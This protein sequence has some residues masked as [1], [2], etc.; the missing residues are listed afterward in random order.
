VLEFGPEAI[1]S[2]WRVGVSEILADHRGNARHSSRMIERRVARVLGGRTA[3]EGSP[4]DVEL[5]DGMRIEVRCFTSRLSLA[6]SHALGV[7]AHS[8]R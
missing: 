8:Y 4:Y 5:A 7:G 1:A 2:G 3:S 6:P